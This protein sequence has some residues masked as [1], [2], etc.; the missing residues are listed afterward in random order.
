MP[1]VRLWVP[2]SDH[3]SKAVGCIANKIVALYGGN[4]TIQLAT[5]QGFNTAIHPKIQDGLKKAV[6]T[7]LKNHNL[8]IFLLDSDGTQSQNQ[9]H[10]IRKEILRLIKLKK[11]LNCLKVKEE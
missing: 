9:R 5:K 8:V 2:E 7:Y 1:S 3:D 6:D 4:I 11:L 10:K